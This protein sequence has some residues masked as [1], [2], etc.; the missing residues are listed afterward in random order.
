MVIFGPSIPVIPPTGVGARVAAAAVLPRALVEV[1]ARV[2]VWRQLVAWAPVIAYMEESSGRLFEERTSRHQTKLTRETG[3]VVRA[4]GVDTELATP[5]A[6]PTRPALV[7]VL[8]HQALGV[9]AAVAGAAAEQIGRDH[10]KLVR[11]VTCR[12]GSRVCWRTAARTRRCPRRTR[13]CRGRC[14]WRGRGRGRGGS[15]SCSVPAC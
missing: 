13:P 9:H 11:C 12:S 8:A 3:T 14:G 7:L 15:C 6:P 2:V 1:P 5:T 4:R 10:A